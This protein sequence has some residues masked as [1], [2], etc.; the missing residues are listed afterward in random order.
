MKSIRFIPLAIAAAV[1]PA[2]LSVG[3]A[4]AQTPSLTQK[5]NAYIGC[6][7]RLSER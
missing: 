7:N 4:T 2:L 3:P 5:L 6:I 1:L